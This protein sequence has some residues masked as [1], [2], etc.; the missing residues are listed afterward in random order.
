MSAVSARE[1][2][3]V[4]SSTQLPSPMGIALC[5]NALAIGTA[6]GLVVFRGVTAGDSSITFL[7]V[8][9][10]K[11]GNVSIHDCVWS[12]GDLLF[13]NTLFSSICSTG[14]DCNFEILWRPD[15]V[16]EDG[17]LDHCHAN[18]MAVVKPGRMLVTSLSSTG[19]REGWR[20]IG[21][22]CGVLI[23]TDAGIV[24]EGLSVP[25][26]PVVRH[27]RVWL[28]ESGTGRLL[29]SAIDDWRM[30]IFADLKSFCRGLTL[31]DTHAFVGLSKV[32]PGSAPSDA[33]IERFGTSESCSVVVL[34][35]QTGVEI[36]R[37]N[38]PHIDEISSLHIVPS[39]IVDFA[40]MNAAD[41]NKTFVCRI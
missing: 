41:A 38:M 6:S 35:L 3:C 14:I 23:D 15:F 29:S 32:R 4:L 30:D 24:A 17:P 21:T 39:P 36:G 37:V 34:C 25:H 2:G 22:D 18:G 19:T 7:P 28:L 16:K 1:H 33:L 12:D 8:A 26:S 11:T 31:T 9:Y 13:L 20:N 40:G 10:H 5:G 27:N